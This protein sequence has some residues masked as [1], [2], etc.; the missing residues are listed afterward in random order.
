M[1]IE[2]E[3]Q[4]GTWSL[5]SDQVKLYEE[6]GGTKGTTLNGAPCVILWTMGRK[7]GNVRKSPVV[8]V[9]AGER[10]AVLGSMG[11]APKDPSW[12]L[13]IRTH[14]SVTLQDGPEVRDYVARELDGDERTE[15]WSKATEVWPAYNEYQSKTDR[16]IPVFL[17]DPA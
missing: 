7:S 13:N 11:G 8:R 16:V 3:Y 4:P 6:S 14:P 15:W 9:N 5:A 10:Y 17:L 1:P 2:G 12:V